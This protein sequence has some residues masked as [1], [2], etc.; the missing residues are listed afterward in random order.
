M[1]KRQELWRSC[2]MGTDKDIKY[3]RLLYTKFILGLDKVKLQLKGIIQRD[4]PRTYPRNTWV[5]NNINTINQ[6]LIEYASIH[7]G[8][9]YLQGF[10]FLMSIVYKVFEGNTYEREDTWWCFCRIVG[11]I[12]PLIPDFNSNWFHW[13]RNYW[14]NHLLQRL[15][16]TRPQLHSI[17]IKHQ[18]RFSVLITC[19]WFMLWFAQNIDFDEILVLWDFLVKTQSRN[20]LKVY[21]IIMYEIL[22][23]AA[24]TL[25]YRWSQEPSEL[26]HELLT[27][28]I[29]GIDKLVKKI[30]KSV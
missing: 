26:L 5:Q 10:N 1:D 11:L 18:E 24:P 12:R 21:T 9:G 16:K 20:L 14:V 15:S 27:I 2:L 30:S 23:E 13:S 28:R 8:D 4:M 3:K 29:K 17:L 7:Q 19:K 6:L 22:N 25:T